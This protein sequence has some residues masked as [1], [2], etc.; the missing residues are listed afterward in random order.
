MVDA[1]VV[2]D[3]RTLLLGMRVLLECYDCSLKLQVDCRNVNVSVNGISVCAV[4][5]D[6]SR[7]CMTVVVCVCWQ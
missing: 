3:D 1:G 6:S 4:P 2:I 5:C 7:M